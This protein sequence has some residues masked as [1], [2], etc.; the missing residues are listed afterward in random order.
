MTSIKITAAISY[1]TF[2]FFLL[3][4]SFAGSRLSLYS[5]LVTCCRR[6][7]RHL[8][9]ALFLSPIP[10]RSLDLNTLPYSYP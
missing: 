3:H 2:P 5:L 7:F 10:F 6:L 9:F 4:Y 8:L 1:F